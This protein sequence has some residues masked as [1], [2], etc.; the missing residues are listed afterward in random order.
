MPSPKYILYA[1]S[2]ISMP[3]HLHIYINVQ[4]KN[5]FALTH[6]KPVPSACAP[7][8]PM[9]G[10]C[11]LLPRHPVPSTCVIASM[12]QVY[13]LFFSIFVMF[14]VLLVLEGYSYQYVKFRNISRSKF[15]CMS[16]PAEICQYNKN[17]NVTLNKINSALQRYSYC[18]PTPSFC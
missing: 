2:H 3:S 6:K 11:A 1:L 17:Y 9:T 15:H 10:L 7:K 14:P 13:G 18:G 12:H 8:H 4:S 16:I 5:V